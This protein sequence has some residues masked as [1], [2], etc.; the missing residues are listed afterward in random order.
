MVFIPGGEFSMGTDSG[1]PFEGPSHR[2][3]VEGFYLDATEVTNRD[4][5]AFV[6]ATGYVTESEKQGSSGVFDTSTGEWSLVEGADWNHPG[7]PDSTIEGRE[8]HPVI[9][10]SW[11]D[12]NAFAQWAG[13]HLPTEAEWEYA[14]RG[15]RG[16]VL[17]PWGDDI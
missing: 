15:G 5:R 6:Q 12:A 13:K 8:D 3:K 4:F 7:G 1:Y 14:A 17:Y 10:V 11:N 16:D 2:A 9:H